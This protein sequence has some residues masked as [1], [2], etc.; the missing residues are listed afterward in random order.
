VVTGRPIRP[1]QFVLTYGIGSI[2]ET[3]GGS[4][5]IPS[6][7][8]W[9]KYFLRYYTRHEIN[10]SSAINQLVQLHE[11]PRIF[12][13][14]TNADLNFKDSKDIYNLEGFPKWSVCM[15][16]SGNPIL[17]Q[18]DGKG[19]LK[20]PECASQSLPEIRSTGIRFVTAC[21]VGH[22]SDVDWQALVPKT[23]DKC[24]HQVFEWIGE[25]QTTRDLRINCTKCQ[26]TI[27]LSDIYRMSR[28][29]QLRC[30]GTFVEEGDRSDCGRPAR[31]ILRSSSSLRM[32]EVQTTL[33]IP[34]RDTPLYSILSADTYYAVISMK[35]NWTIHELCE[36]LEMIMPR[37]RKIKRQEIQ[38]I[39]GYSDEELEQVLRQLSRDKIEG[40][41]TDESARMDEFSAL[42]NASERG[43]PPE[44]SGRRT[45][46]E[47]ERLKI[48]PVPAADNKWGVPFVVTPIKTLNV[49][50][51]QRGYRRQLGT[52]GELVK[53]F[54][55]DEQGNAWFPGIEALGE[56]IFIRLATGAALSKNGRWDDWMSLFLKSGRKANIHPVFIWWHSLAHRIINALSI[57]S[58]YSSASIRERIFIEI[59]KDNPANARGG[60]LLYSVQTGGDGTLGGLISLVPKFKNVLQ[61][62]ASNLDSCSNDPLCGMQTITANG[63]NGAACYACLLL[64]ETSCE[65]RNRWLD[66]SLLRSI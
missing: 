52:N 60:M 23:D 14:P 40:E 58:G 44:H 32:P 27:R 65:N 39:R 3:S 36:N 11:S 4:K 7:R 34:H 62:A 12:K 1:S 61:R 37:N 16:H 21:T 59:D 10:D 28:G 19:Y 49:V 29:N 24:K 41:V 43:H 54:Y 15:A 50:L 17:S 46:F 31:L 20:C 42:L 63:D 6:F 33:T 51:V 25:G 13:I 30:K 38:T 9:G 26:S 8:R 45:K 48:N 22:L 2:I 66:R 5:V 64:S 56:G 55:E 57:D 18:M 53:T 35:E 47:V